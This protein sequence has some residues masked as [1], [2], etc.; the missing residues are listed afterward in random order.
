MVTR[1]ELAEEDDL[2]FVGLIR[3]ELDVDRRDAPGQQEERAR[4]DTTHESIVAVIRVG[5]RPSQG[6]REDAPSRGT[7]GL[8]WNPGA[9]EVGASSPGRDSSADG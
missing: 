2:A 1:P 5:S 8:T 9:L 3:D 6:T 4:D 7:P